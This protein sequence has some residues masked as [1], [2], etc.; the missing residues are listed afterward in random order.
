MTAA[1]VIDDG[2]NPPVTGSVDR[3]SSFIGNLFT[4]SNF[5]N[6]GV[7][8]HRWTLVDKPI[9]SSASLT[10]TT[11]P[12]TTITAD[13]AGS[14]LVRLETYLD[15]S[16]TDLD[17]ADEQVVGVRFDAPHNWPIPAAGETTQQDSRGWAEAREESIRDVRANLMPPPVGTPSVLAVA[18]TT[19]M[20]AQS[21]LLYDPSA[22][23]GTHTIEAPASPSLGDRWAIK[24]VT[25][26]PVSVAI[27]GNGTPIED[28]NTN[29]IIASYALA[30]GLV[31]LDYLFTGTD[32][33]L[34]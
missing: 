24:N 32:W 16:A 25:V 14:Y 7:L 22:S 8:A 6:T 23:G 9:G 5:D 1:I 29:T 13:V 4:L 19:T 28:P 10:S 30:A 17:D 31:S 27:D 12:I 21:L 18:G 34:L 3:D 20:V 11:T 26:S 2:T 15:A 33:V